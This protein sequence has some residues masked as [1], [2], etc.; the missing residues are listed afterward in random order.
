MTLRIL[1]KMAVV[2]IFAVLLG[3]F[4]TVWASLFFNNFLVSKLVAWGIPAHS[5]VSTVI[6]P[7]PIPIP[8]LKGGIKL[9]TPQPGYNATLLMNQTVHFKWDVQKTT[10]NFVIKNEKGKKIFE[11]A[12]SDKSSLDIVPVEV[13]LKTG[14]K[15]FWTVDDNATVYEFTVLDSQS[16]K[17]LLDTFAE[18][19]E[20]GLSLE[21]CTIKKAA[22]V[23]G[24]SDYA[25]DELDFYWLSAQWLSKISP[26]DEE[27]KIE[28]D[29]LL[30]EYNKHI[31]IQHYKI[32]E[33]L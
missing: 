12:I 2:F 23:Q 14:Q 4:Q 9:E 13:K 25:K 17:I 26:T 30:E 7:L 19:D 33:K 28:R 5:L 1:S 16:E 27:T 10:G 3:S 22:Y 11:T 6:K 8:I 20:E 31:L 18:I 24:L 21:K 15:Y 29:Y 32:R